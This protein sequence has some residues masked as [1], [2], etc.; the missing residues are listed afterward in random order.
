MPQQRKPYWL[1]IDLLVVI[2]S[3]GIIGMVA[4]IAP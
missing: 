3:V 2:I 1:Q 4:Q